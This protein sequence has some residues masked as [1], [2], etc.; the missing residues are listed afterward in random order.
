MFLFSFVLVAF[1]FGVTVGHYKIFPFVLIE[2]AKDSV[3]LVI[4]ERETLAGIRP[5]HYLNRSRYVG[6]GVTRIQSDRAAPGWTLISGFFEDTNELRLV[7][8]DGS[9]VRRWRV[10]FSDMF[11]D[12][13]HIK[14]PARIPKTDWNVGLHGALVLPDG[15]VVF[16]FDN[17][18][19]VKLDRCGAVQWTVPLMAHH[20]VDQAEDGGFWVPGRRFVETDSAFP[21]IPTPYDEDTIL[22]IS[23]D[24]T[25]LQEISVPALFMKNGLQAVLFANGLSQIGVPE[26]ELVHLNDIEEL[27]SDLAAS[28]PEFATGDLIIS[29]RELN[30]IMVVDPKT[31]RVKWHQTGPWLRQH[32]PDFQ[33]DGTIT[34]FN[35]NS[36]DTEDGRLFG[37][38]NIIEIDPSTRN[39]NIRF[40]TGA[41]QKF[42]S[43]ARGKHQILANGNVLVTESESGRIFEG[44][45]DGQI[46]WE[47]I[48]RFDADFT[49][50]V[51][52]ATRYPEQYFTVNSWACG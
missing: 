52:E 25:V 43:N 36:D 4:E 50:D 51:T 17:Y 21:P 40:G 35:N 14:P 31:E 10:R 9:I 42:F 32:D 11:S 5:T 49:A 7:R 23:A 2:F 16:N 48:N 44:T 13:S 3:E 47:F 22:K 20:S 24:G 1:F 18:G 8:L 12:T 26:T 28:F 34:V 41:G 45:P 19:L 30:L 39:T 29:M 33:A 27:K 38:S 6:S 37:G 46:V 15:S